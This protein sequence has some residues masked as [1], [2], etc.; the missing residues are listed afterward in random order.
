LSL[1]SAHCL[2]EPPDAA[3][4]RGD[5][6]TKA[7]DVAG[8]GQVHAVQRAPGRPLDPPAHLG[9]DAQGQAG[10]VGEHLGLD[11]LLQ[12]AAHGALDG[13]ETA[14]PQRLACHRLH[15]L[16]VV[17]RAAGCRARAGS[18]PCNTHNRTTPTLEEPV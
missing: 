13:V 11:Q 2:V 16:D 4:E 10:G 7:G 14:P 5:L 3:V 1:L 6:L 8:G 9:P 17:Q 15:L 12:T 18:M